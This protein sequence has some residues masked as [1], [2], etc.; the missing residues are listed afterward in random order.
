VPRAAEYDPA[1]R[2]ML[3]NAYWTASSAACTPPS[4]R[5]AKE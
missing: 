3:M 5:K 1:R 2:Q 4:I